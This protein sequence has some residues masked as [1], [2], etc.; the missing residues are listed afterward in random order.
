MGEW[1]LAEMCWLPWGGS[2]DASSGGPVAGP[3]GG[4]GIPL[5]VGEAQKRAVQVW[6]QHRRRGKG[7]QSRAHVWRQRCSLP[8]L[9]PP[10][11]LEPTPGG[12]AVRSC[13]TNRCPGVN[14]PALPSVKMKGRRQALTQCPC[15]SKWLQLLSGVSS[16]FPEVRGGLE[17]CFGRHPIPTL[18]SHVHC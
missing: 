2:G 10:A 7:R 16:P 12:P 9:A 18:N 4:A 1:G 3:C 15:P 6:K 11:H 17:P 13:V 8:T 5:L 14:T